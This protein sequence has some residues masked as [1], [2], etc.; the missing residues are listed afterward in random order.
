MIGSCA[1]DQKVP[2][3]STLNNVTAT[4]VTKVPLKI[5]NAK[6]C[7]LIAAVDFV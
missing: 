6:H 1:S 7:V 3:G 2:L 4:V 5:K